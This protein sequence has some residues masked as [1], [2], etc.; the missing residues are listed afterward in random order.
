MVNKSGNGNLI[1]KAEHINQS[2]NNLLSTDTKRIKNLNAEHW[3]RIN[4]LDSRSII[5]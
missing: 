1:R 3:G 4:Y 5:K 2:D